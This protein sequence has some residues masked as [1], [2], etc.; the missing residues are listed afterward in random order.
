[1]VASTRR[2]SYDIV[3]GNI[4]VRPRCRPRGCPR[5][6]P[7]LH[8]RDRRPLLPRGWAWGPRR[9]CVPLPR[10]LLLE[11]YGSREEHQSNKADQPGTGRAT[12]TGD[13]RG[14]RVDGG[15]S[16]ARRSRRPAT[17][18]TTQALLQPSVEPKDDQPACTSRCRCLGWRKAGSRGIG[19]W[20]R[21]RSRGLGSDHPATSR[22]PS[23]IFVL[24]RSRGDTGA[25]TGSRLRKPRPDDERTLAR[26]GCAFHPLQYVPHRR[27]RGTST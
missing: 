18:D 6:H 17:S 22:R 16:L 19:H 3:V 15:G 1:M 13:A 23:I 12:L 8:S 24:G 4:G 25:P 2:S 5:R 26:R 10:S 9:S 7:R 27:G 11:R 20:G 14:C 21:G